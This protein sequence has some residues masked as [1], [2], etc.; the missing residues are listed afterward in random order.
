[1]PFVN[2]ITSTR[3]PSRNLIWGLSNL[4]L[5]LSSLWLRPEAW[6]FHIHSP[7]LLATCIKKSSSYPLLRVEIADDAVWVWFGFGLGVAW[8]VVLI[9]AGTCGE[10]ER[11]RT[12][13]SSFGITSSQRME[14][15]LMEDETDKIWWILFLKDRTFPP[16]RL[17]YAKWPSQQRSWP[18]GVSDCQ[19]SS[20]LNGNID[21]KIIL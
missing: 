5:S 19:Y 10:G 12:V 6:T 13:I 2:G 20:L 18:A 17:Y 11:G 16:R 15:G 9:L 21:R 7:F 8:A 1:M 4:G 14:T 3:N